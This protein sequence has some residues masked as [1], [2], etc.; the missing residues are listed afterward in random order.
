MTLLDVFIPTTGIG[1]LKQSLTNVGT[2][3]Y[4]AE[5]P[6]D[7]PTLVG[8]IIGQIIALLGVLFLA[9]TVYGG[10]KWMMARGNEQEVEK[11]KE[12]IKAG[13]IGLGIMLGAYAITNLVISRFAKETIGGVV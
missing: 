11:A 6:P 9:L 10:Y 5:T 2:Q 3:A 1:K 7:L 8:R 12:T 4:G 13:I